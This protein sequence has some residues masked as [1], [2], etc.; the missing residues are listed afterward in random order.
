MITS[1]DK[2]AII[3]K[4]NLKKL[5]E[6]GGYFSEAYKSPHLMEIAGSPFRRHS[7]TSI[8]YLL[9]NDEPICYFHIDK[10]DVIHFFHSGHPVTFLTIDSEGTLKEVLLGPDVSKGHVPQ[11]LVKGG[12]W[13]AA[14]LKEGEF[15]LLSEVVSPG[16][17]ESDE[18][19][20]RVEV[21]QN[22]FPH[23]WDKIKLYVKK[24]PEVLA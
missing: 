2:N 3:N 19:L 1:S 17:H 18:K 8:Y 12:T 13:K 5:S 20:G 24:C 6:V 7:I 11:M 15:G 23:L 22:L 16:F 4:L 9:A 14:I 21:L 10:S